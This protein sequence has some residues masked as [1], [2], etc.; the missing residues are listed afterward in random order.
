[1]TSA[2]LKTTTDMI[3]ATTHQIQ[4][5]SPS[6][7]HQRLVRRFLAVRRDTLHG[8]PFGAWLTLHIGFTQLLLLV[9]WKS[10][11]AGPIIH[12]GS[13]HHDPETGWHCIR[14]GFGRWCVNVSKRLQLGEWS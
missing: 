6:A 12:L 3:E 5:A 1:M 11:M 7:W 14:W 9:P 13:P 2:K 8:Q 10:Q 4:Q